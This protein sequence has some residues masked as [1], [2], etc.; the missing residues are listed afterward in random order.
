MSSNKFC[1]LFH[2]LAY[3]TN[4]YRIEVIG[5]QNKFRDSLREL[6]HKFIPESLDEIYN[7]LTTI[8]SHTNTTT[9]EETK[10]LETI[11]RIL[12]GK[13]FESV[14]F[15]PTKILNS[16]EQSSAVKNQQIKEDYEKGVKR[17]NVIYDESRNTLE[18]YF[19][20]KVNAMKIKE[21]QRK[22]S[23]VA[24]ESSPQETNIVNITN[25][26]QEKLNILR[27]LY[28]NELRSIEKVNLISI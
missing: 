28:K 7:Y 1:L 9:S 11:Q 13:V 3:G 19:R 26:H 27:K 5:L 25:D 10:K 21:P 24:Q 18:E 15:N 14:V 23:K 17:V 20:K 4:L 6:V 22:G 8:N 12:K 2:I 16:T